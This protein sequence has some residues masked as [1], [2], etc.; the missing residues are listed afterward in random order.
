[1]INNILFGKSKAKWNR[2]SIL[3][4]YDNLSGNTMINT[5]IQNDIELAIMFNIHGVAYLSHETLHKVFFK[6]EGRRTSKM[7]DVFCTSRDWIYND[8]T[9]LCFHAEKDKEFII[10]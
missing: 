9:G 1:M 2:T 3:Y 5:Q 10:E 7:L 4:V 8:D 6:L